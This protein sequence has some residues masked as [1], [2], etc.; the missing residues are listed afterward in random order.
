MFRFSDVFFFASRVVFAVL[1]DASLKIFDTLIAVGRSLAKS[2]CGLR[3]GAARRTTIACP[4]YDPHAIA[5][6]DFPLPDTSLLFCAAGHVRFLGLFSFDFMPDGQS[7]LNN[8]AKGNS[9]P[10]SFADAARFLG[11]DL[12]TFHSMVQR[13]EIPAFLG[14]SGEFVVSQVDLD[15]LVAEKDAPC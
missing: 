10:V 11:V 7:V 4:G 12:F 5:L 2:V 14:P 3:S 9:P 8:P 1:S 15:K 13:E 6:G